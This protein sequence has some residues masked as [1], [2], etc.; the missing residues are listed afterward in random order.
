MRLLDIIDTPDLPSGRCA[1]ADAD[2]DLWFPPAG[3]VGH[4]QAREAKRVCGGCD[5]KDEC[6]S[7]AMASESIPGRM[8]AGVWGGLT[9]VERGKLA[10]KIA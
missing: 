2:P 10:R 5:V 4:L 7:F 6:L 8:R 9:A 1:Q 3:A